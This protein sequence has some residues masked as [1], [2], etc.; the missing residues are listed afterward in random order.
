LSGTIP[1]ATVDDGTRR[2][3]FYNDTAFKQYLDTS[4]PASLS[5]YLDEFRTYPQVN[6]ALL[7]YVDECLKSADAKL[8]LAPSILIGATSEL[9]VVRLVK[10]I[11]DYL[12]DPNMLDR[13]YRK[14][15]MP[16]K[17]SYTIQTVRLGRERLEQSIALNAHQANT[18]N[19]FG[20]IV[21][22]LFDS[23]R[24]RRNEY[25]H[26]EPEVS[27]ENLPSENVINANAQGFNPYARVILT[28]INIF[29]ENIQSS[30]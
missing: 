27:L 25:V 18:F 10:A 21:V 3:I 6:G 29:K 16:S 13:Y 19:E 8:R 23:I 24:L 14:R 2:F 22:H 9:L 7:T 30:E 4:P 11:G 5:S 12:E 20:N 17:Q 15:T 28:L 1:V 26:P